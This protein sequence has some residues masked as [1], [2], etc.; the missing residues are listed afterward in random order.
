MNCPSC[1][2]QLVDN[3]CPSCGSYFKDGKFIYKGDVMSRP[4]KEDYVFCEN[5][6][7]Y[8]H[9]DKIKEDFFGTPYCPICQKDIKKE[10]KPDAEKE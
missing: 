3:K 1:K 6:Q 2:K 4:N 9:K 5:C 8:I 10:E 7:S